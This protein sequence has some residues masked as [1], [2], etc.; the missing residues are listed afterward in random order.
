MFSFV[1]VEHTQRGEIA[2]VARDISVHG[3]VSRSLFGVGGT[4]GT[5]GMLAEE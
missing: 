4:G 1:E 2:K 3:E 5:R